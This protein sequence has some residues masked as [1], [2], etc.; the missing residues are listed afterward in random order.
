MPRIPSSPIIF[1]LVWAMA[2]LAWALA[3]ASW[4][5]ML[6][7]GAGQPVAGTTVKL[8]SPATGHDYTAR[9]SAEG[10]FSFDAITPGT[11][12]VSAEH[13]DQNWTLPNALTIHEG[14]LIAIL[15]FSSRNKQ[16]RME[17][18]GQESSPQASGG[19][20]LSSGEESSR[21][22]NSSAF[23]KLFLLAAGPMPQPNG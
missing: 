3:N 4:S 18:S 1:L 23:G 11:Y 12:E 5:G 6:R 19:D 20:R 13:N 17:D 7:D 2:G 22:L 15:R 10:K 14:V 8:H 16:L 21:P 9:T